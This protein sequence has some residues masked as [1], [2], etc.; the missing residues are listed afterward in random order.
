MKTVFFSA[1]LLLGLGFSAQA[2]NEERKK[3]LTEQ[4]QKELKVLSEHA[5]ELGELIAKE[6]ESN[7]QEDSLKVQIERTKK[8][9]RESAEK[10]KNYS[11]ELSEDYELSDEQKEL[12]KESA[13]AFAQGMRAFGEAMSSMADNLSRMI[14]DMRSQSNKPTK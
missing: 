10:I 2:Q 13:D 3:E 9:I 1:L 12:L 5:T 8:A 11:K 6:I 7:M 4:L 14:D